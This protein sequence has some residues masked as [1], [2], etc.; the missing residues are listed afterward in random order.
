[1]LHDDG[2]LIDSRLPHHEA[3]VKIR[4]AALTTARQRYPQYRHQ[5]FARVLVLHIVGVTGWAGAG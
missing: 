1:L 2:E 4:A 3:S 5:P